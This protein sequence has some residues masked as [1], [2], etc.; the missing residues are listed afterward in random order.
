MDLFL[1]YMQ[2]F[3]SGIV[4]IVF[5]IFV[6]SHLRMISKQDEAFDHIHGLPTHGE[7]FGHE[8]TVTLEEGDRPQLHIEQQGRH[9][10]ER[11][12]VFLTFIRCGGYHGFHPLGLDGHLDNMK[13]T[14]ITYEIL[15][16]LLTDGT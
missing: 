6:V 10:R 9:S 5:F 14:R 12:Q 8:V 11:F 15:V 3:H 2:S 1:L 4:K 7:H 13:K 16:G